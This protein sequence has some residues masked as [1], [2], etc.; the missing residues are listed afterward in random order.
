MNIHHA[1]SRP[2]FT[3]VELLVVIAIIAVLIGLLLPAVQSAREAARRS[4]CTS[5]MKQ[6]GLA[7]HQYNSARGGFP[8]G[9]SDGG[10]TTHPFFAPTV[11]DLQ[12]TSGYTVTD[13]VYHKRD[14]WFHRLLPFVEQVTLSD[15]YEADRYW[16]THQIPKTQFP[17]TIVSTFSCASDPSSPCN[18][19]G[20]GGFMGNYGL[21]GGN[22]ADPRSSA[23]RGMFGARFKPL[24]TTGFGVVDCTD[25][26]SK[27]L[28]ASESIIRGR[29][30]GGL[31][32]EMGAYWMGGVWGECSF[33]TLEPPNT[34][35]P[36]RPYQCTST[37][38]PQAPCETT[39]GTGPLR[40]F[41][42]SMHVGGVNALMCD[43]AVR[44]VVNAIDLTIW[45]NLGD[46]AD[47]NAI[48]DF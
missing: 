8:Y 10:F 34:T 18:N 14:T 42:R 28:M 31:F 37:T 21:C 20:S 39:M 13:P 47:G 25:G 3:L 29:N 4:S 26:L 38:W 32:G 30:S 5:N 16:H 1:R 41:A 12:G 43:G 40:N 2:G 48:G 17:N 35:V 9:W 19:N 22:M 6:I 27:T 24:A 33:S 15:R 44:Q 46:K 11:G 23:P 7:M 36:D 45:R